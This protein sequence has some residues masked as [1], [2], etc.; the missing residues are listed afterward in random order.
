MESIWWVFKQLYVKGLVY[1]GV[2]VMPYSTACTTALSNFESGQ[3]YKEVVDPSVV[4]CFPIVDSADNTSLVIWTTT[5]WTLPSNMACCVHPEH[6]YVK[7]REKSTGKHFILMQARLEFVFKSADKVEILESFPGAKLSGTRYNP[8]FD[9]FLK[10]KSNAFKVLCD[11]YVTDDGGT[12]CVHQAP[13]FGEDDYRVCL[14]NGV[15]TRDQ[16]IVCPLDASGKFT[17]PVTDFVGQFVKDADKNIIANLK[18]RGLLV[19]HG[20]TKHSYPFCWRSDTPL[21]YKAVPSWFVRVQHMQEQLLKCSSDTYWVPDYVKEKRFG[22]WLREARDWAISRNRYWG[23]PIP[24]WMSENGD[25]IVCVG[26]IEELQKFSGVTVTD[27][28]RETVDKITIPSK[29]PGNPPLK[30][31]TEVFDCWFESGSMPY[32]QEHFPFENMNEFANKFPADF[33]AEGKLE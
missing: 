11:T 30:R 7:V 29:I 27:L 15:I 4:V 3:N 22:N 14:A 32:A 20:Q 10:Y 16:E 8:P 33:I 2:K 31:V 18:Q 6:V 26:S 28:H 12:G 19:F 21:I 17:P 25:E 24:L 5:P 13:Y 1:Q 23:T 9:Y